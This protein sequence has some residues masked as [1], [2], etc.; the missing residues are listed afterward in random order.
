LSSFWVVE[1]SAAAAVCCCLGVAYYDDT[2]ELPPLDAM[3]YHGTSMP[4]VAGKKQQATAK[5]ASE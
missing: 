5:P 3:R 2:L 4:A 1:T